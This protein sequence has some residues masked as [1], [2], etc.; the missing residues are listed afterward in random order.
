MADVLSNLGQAIPPAAT[1]TA[2]FTAGG[3]SIGVMVSSVWACNQSAS[4]PAQISISVA[5]AGAADTPAQ[6]LI[7]NVTLQPN[8]S[9]SFV[10]G[11]SM[12]NGDVM[13]VLSSTGNVSFNAFGVTS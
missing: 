1:L 6:Y 3:S 2:L 7:Y 10:N 9:R 4:A 8:E 11:I 12:A 13:R 5:V